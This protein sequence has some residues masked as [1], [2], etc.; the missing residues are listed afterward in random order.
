MTLIRNLLARLAAI[1]TFTR[2]RSVLA[3]ADDALALSSVTRKMLIWL[4]SHVDPAQVRRGAE[5]LQSMD[6]DDQGLDDR[7]AVLLHDLADWLEARREERRHH[8]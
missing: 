4:E 6:S 8:G 7:A 5:L 3:Y 1:L 2:I